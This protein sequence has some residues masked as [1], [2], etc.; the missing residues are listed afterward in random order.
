WKEGTVLESLR[1]TPSRQRAIQD[2]RRAEGWTYDGDVLQSW[3]DKQ[4]NQVRYTQGADYLERVSSSGGEIL[5]YAAH[6]MGTGVW[7]LDREDLIV[8]A[9]RYVNRYTYDASGRIAQQ[10][11]QY[12]NTAACNHIIDVTA[13]YTYSGDD[14]M[15]VALK[16]G[17]EGFPAEGSPKTEWQA[18]VNYTYDDKARV[19]KEELAVTSFAKTYQQKPQGALRDDIN[20]LFIGGARVKKPIENLTRT[21]DLCASAGAQLLS[22]PID[23]R[24]FYA[25]SPNLAMALQNGVTKAIVTFTYPDAFTVK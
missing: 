25:M 19:S 23:L 16:G 8:D 12:Q 2:A 7:L 6:P 13:D 15:S 4:G 3:S 20:H 21:G 14:L 9:Q 22:N 11:T 10:Q 5:T 24:P 18:A 1:Y 17:Y